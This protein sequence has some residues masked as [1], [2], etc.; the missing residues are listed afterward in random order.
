MRIKRAILGL[1][2]MSG[3]GLLPAESV[4]AHH[5]F[6]AEFDATKPI[7]VQGTL[8]KIQW[9]NPHTWWHVDVK[10]AEGQV[11]RWLFEGGAPGSLARRGFTKDFVPVGTEIVVEG[12]MS[13]GVARRANGRSMTH[14]DGRTLFMGSSGTGEPKDGRDPTEK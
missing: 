10:N 8:V 11:E 7:K 4:R 13:K 14:A 9:T 2:A 5:A 3:V 12:F 6:S 1:V